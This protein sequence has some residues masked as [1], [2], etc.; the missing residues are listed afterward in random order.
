MESLITIGDGDDFLTQSIKT[1]MFED[2]EDGD[3]GID[4]NIIA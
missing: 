3:R 4:L 2:M 1:P